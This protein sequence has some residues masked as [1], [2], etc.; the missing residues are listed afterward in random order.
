MAA[1]RPKKNIE[2]VLPPASE[3][4]MLNPDLKPFL[5]AWDAKWAVLPPGTS[6][7]DRRK[8]F[9]VIAAEMRLPTPEAVDCSAEHWIDSKAG[10]VRVRVFRHRDGGVQPCLIYMHGGAWMQGSPETH[11]DITARIADWNRQTVISVVLPQPEAPAA[12]VNAA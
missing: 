9:E 12:P 5:A 10:P 2:P 3:A 7:A 8:R 4:P 1:P 6:P 11:W